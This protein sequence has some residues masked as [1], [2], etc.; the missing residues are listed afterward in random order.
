MRKRH[1]RFAFNPDPSLKEQ[2]DAIAARNPYGGALSFIFSQI[3][4]TTTPKSSPRPMR[5]ISSLADLQIL[6][7]TFLSSEARGDRARI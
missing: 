7:R 6:M 4:S 2:F 1:A 5:D 3:C